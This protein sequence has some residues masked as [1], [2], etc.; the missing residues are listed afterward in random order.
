MEE[1]P[2]TNEEIAQNPPA[3][4][5]P[6][7]QG[8]K[9][10]NGS[11]I[12]IVILAILATAGIGFGIYGFFFKKSEEKPAQNAADTAELESELTNLKDKY[13]VLQN[14]VKELEASGTEISEEIKEATSINTREYI[15][16]ASWGQKI[17]IPSELIYIEYKFTG[18]SDMECLHVN[19]GRVEDKNLAATGGPLANIDVQ[20]LG[21][22][23]RGG[24]HR[25][26]AGEDRWVGDPAQATFTIGD[27]SY[28]YEGPNGSN[29][30]AE[31]AV[32][33]LIKSMLSNPSNYS[34][35]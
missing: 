9:P 16:I 12:A 31:E 23:C 32:A 25:S 4:N 10:G 33:T 18:Y 26:H 5:K 24:S 11:K 3:L 15:Y 30:E 35:I 14:Y 7:K 1:K 8:S 13:S 20:A 34:A 17:K 19:A 28:W 2:E 27:Y 22:V 29:S 6:E 21:Y